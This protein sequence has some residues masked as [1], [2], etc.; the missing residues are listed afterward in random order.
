MG[1]VLAHRMDNGSERPIGYMSR[2]LWKVERGYSQLE[3]EGLV[4]IFSLRKFHQYLYGK[5]CIIVTDH[6]PLLGLFVEEKAVPHMVAARIH[7]WALT[8]AAYITLTLH[9]LYISVQGRNKTCTCIETPA[10]AQQVGEVV[11]LVEHME[12]TPVHAGQI[13]TWARQTRFYPKSISQR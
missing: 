5:H 12:G 2:T 13:K 7:S 4:I 1:A 10:S 3:K 9:Y 6:K 8:L 11:R